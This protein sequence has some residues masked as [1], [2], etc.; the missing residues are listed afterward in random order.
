MATPLDK[1]LLEPLLKRAQETHSDA[2][3]VMHEGELIGTWRFGK[4]KQ[5]IETMS[6]TKS[7]VNLAIGKLISDGLL[8]SIDEP[9]CV[10]YPEWKQGRKKN[11]TIKHIMNHSSGLQNLPNAG[12]E[13]NSSPDLIQLAL[14]AEISDEPGSRLSYNNKAVNI[15]AG[16]VEKISGQKLDD[17]MRDKLF[18][19]LEITEFYWGRDVAKNPSVLAGLML[20]PEDL[21]KL[22]QFVLNRGKWQNQQMIDTRWFELMKSQP[23]ETGLLWWLIRDMTVTIDDSH[24]ANLQKTS[25][26]KNVT[27]AFET[28]KGVYQTG[29]FIP[30]F[31]KVFGKSWL[32]TR[33][34]LETVK[35]RDV[36]YQDV[37]GYQANGDLGQN[38]YIFEKQQLVFVRMIHY[39]TYQN[40]T[41]SFN[42][43]SKIV[44]DIAKSL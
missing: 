17:Y 9:V 25:I 43:F 44:T 23:G 20:F 34:M 3:V 16:L 12:E 4:P 5:L 15:L 42:D 33:A 18:A 11:I 31:Q 6:I 37:Q 8:T 14:C 21:A 39:D 7:I 35:Y 13:I 40:E 24:I 2:I 36:L 22:G 32:E 26:S 1:T 30:A 38:L 19:P 27:K 41:D 10:F 28:L 29:K